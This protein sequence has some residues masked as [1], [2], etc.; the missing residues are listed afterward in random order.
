MRHRKSRRQIPS[1]KQSQWV[2]AKKRIFERYGLELNSDDRTE[3]LIKIQKG[4]TQPIMNQS[5]RLVV[6][7][8]HYKK[9][10]FLVYDKQRQSI[11]TAL[12]KEMVDSQLSGEDCGWTNPSQM[13]EERPFGW[14]HHSIA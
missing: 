14:E 13:V 12:T 8:V 3:L 10:M 1:K 5:N 7:R 2:H 6:H 11:V 4:H 9:V